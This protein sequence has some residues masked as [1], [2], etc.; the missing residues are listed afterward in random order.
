MVL[1]VA[2]LVG[3]EDIIHNFLVQLPCWCEVNHNI[4]SGNCVSACVV[5]AESYL[6]YACATVILRN[7]TPSVTESIDAI[8]VFLRHS[9][10]FANSL[11]ANI[12]VGT[13]AV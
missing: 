1:T 10:A 13:K 12:H 5:H 8:E 11:D 7:G 2:I 3:E 9:H 6:S 4:A